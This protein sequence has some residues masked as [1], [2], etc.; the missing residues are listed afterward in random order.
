[1]RNRVCWII[2][3][4][5][6]MSVFSS[7]SDS[8]KTEAE[9]AK[10]KTLSH[11]KKK[12]R[13][14]VIGHSDFLPDRTQIHDRSSIGLPDVL[15]DR[16]LEHLANSKRFVPV[17]RKALR[18]VVLEQRFGQ[19]LQKTYLDRTLDKAI[20]DMEKMDGGMVTG[21]TTEISGKLGLPGVGMKQTSAVAPKP[22]GGGIA[23]G[24]GDVGTTGTLANYNDILKD[25]QDLGT[26]VG[27]DYLVLGNLEKLTRKT[28]ETAVPYSTEGRKV[29]KNVA[30]ARLRLRVIEVKSGM[31]VGATS[32]RTKV[33]ETLFEGKETDTDDYSFFDHLGRLAAVKILDVT[34]PARIVTLDPLILSRGTNDGAKVGDIYVIQREGK[35][36]RDDSGVVIGQLKTDVGRVEILTPQET[37]SIVRPVAEGHFLVND[38]AS[39][40]IQASQA[41]LASIPSTAAVPLSGGTANER[42]IEKKLP[43]VAVG[44]I[45]SG[46]TARTGK[47][48]AEHTPLFTDTIISRLAQTKR[49]QMID[50][51]E[52]DQ[53]LNEQMAQALA[54][55]RDMASAMGT[56]KGAD[57]LAYGSLAHFGLEEEVT[58]L[59]NSSRTFKRKIGYVEGNMRI[60]DARSGEIMESRKIS[61]KEPVDANAEGGRIVSVLANAYAD[62]VVLILMNAIYP[63]KVAAVGGDG[64]IYINRGNDGGL[65]VGETLDAFRPGQAVIDPDT[66]V[67]LGVEE[68]L[69]GQVV[70]N[71]VEDARSKGTF[72]AGSEIVAGDIL[73]RTPENRE[74]RAA[75]ARKPAPSRSGAIL[76]DVSAKSSEKK[77][78]GKATLAVGLLR[79]NQ[80]ARTDSLGDGHIKRLTDDLIVKLTNTNR[81]RVMD[82]QEVDQILDEKA[83]ESMTSGGDIHDRLQKLIGADYLIHGEIS[84]LYTTTQRKKVPFLDE[85]QVHVNGI[86]EGT[87]RIVDV[88]TGGVIAADKVRVNERIKPGGDATQVMSNLMDGFTTEAVSLIVG[89][90]FPIKILGTTADGTVYLNRGMDVGLENGSIFDVMRPGQELIDPDTGLSFGKSE[91]KV[92]SVE[93]VSVEASRSRAIVTSGKDVKAGDVLRKLQAA[94]KKPEAKKKRVMRPAW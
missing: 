47:D 40:D 7:C 30:D 86:A 24:T 91:T 75:Q 33:T 56:L 45:K 32:L 25:F 65:F 35:E 58:Q 74:K 20:A 63:I 73:K 14:A 94:T 5:F 11:H 46:S 61:I 16:I 42:A 31:V 43:M 87:F 83:F 4:I 60:V 39:L 3:L 88:H 79:L 23:K 53:L 78:G 13:I 36:I 54:Q 28:E 92:A 2:A 18:K 17:E 19:E 15:S 27:A 93:I 29:S 51:Q 90:L 77:Q 37:L 9:P 21:T 69:I 10:P 12:L 26:A 44:L 22:V 76:T 81:F 64:T 59:P 38:L 85:E 52:V 82:R 70:I 48:A 55:G 8:A 71:D 84:N 49:F 62:Q 34:F 57:Y 41:K 80:N 89:R 66:G 67:Q 1:M 68:T 72:A 6:L 50:R